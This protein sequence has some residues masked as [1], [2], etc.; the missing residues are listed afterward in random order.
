M[1]DLVIDVTA[2]DRLGTDLSRVATEFE[3]ANASSS[4]LADAVGH[5]EL[6]STLR[7]FTQK[8]DVTRG[9]MTDALRALSEAS[10]AV[11]EGW[12]D[13]DQQGAEALRGDG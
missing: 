4:R 13:I 1:A 2:I 8:W 12:R 9:K 7:A 10:A 3:Q 11:A 6:G 5:S